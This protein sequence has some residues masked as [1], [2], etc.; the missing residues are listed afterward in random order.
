[1]RNGF[2]DPA[3]RK[4]KGT[5]MADLVFTYIIFFALIGLASACP[6]S[7]KPEGFSGNWAFSLSS[8]LEKS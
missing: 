8:V 5:G 3:A 1:M 6:G 4:G 2:T 7:A